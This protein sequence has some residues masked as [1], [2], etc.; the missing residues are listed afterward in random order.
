MKSNLNDT[1][2]IM[3]AI[4]IVALNGFFNLHFHFDY[5]FFPI[6]AL[7]LFLA[8]GYIQSKYIISTYMYMYNVYMYTY[9]LGFATFPKPA[10]G[11]PA[12]LGTSL[13]W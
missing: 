9:I 13:L 8:N 5:G 7:P 4:M 10:D 11:P 3:G 1:V 6:L 12:V 2:A